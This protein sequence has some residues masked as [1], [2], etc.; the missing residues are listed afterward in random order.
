[1]QTRIRKRVMSSR[2][3][4]PLWKGFIEGFVVKYLKKNNWRVESY[5][6]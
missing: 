5:M 6:T 3:Y 1:M 2:K 4:T